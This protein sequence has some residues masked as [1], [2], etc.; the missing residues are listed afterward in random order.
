MKLPAA[1]KHFWRIAL[2][3]VA[4]YGAA[5]AV[6]PSPYHS[7]RTPKMNDIPPKIAALF[8]KTKPVCF[9]RFMIDLP[10]NAKVIWG[11]LMLP[12]ET[13]VY[14]GQGGMIRAAI[15][16]KVDE[17]TCEKH[18]TEPSMLIGTFDSANPDSKIVVGYENT[19][20]DGGAQ[21]FSY[22]RLGK[23][24]FMQ[25]IPSKGLFVTD[26]NDPWGI[27]MDKNAYKPVVE[28]L[29]DIASRFRPRAEDEIPTDPGVCIEGGFL[30]AGLDYRMELVSIGFR[31]PEYPDVS[32]SVRTWSTDDPSEEDTLA[33]ALARGRK[34]AGLMGLGELYAK[35]RTL[36][37]GERVIGPWEGGEALGRKPG[38]DGGPSVHEFLFRSQGVGKDLLRPRVNID[39][40]TG[41]N[42]SEHSDR[43]LKPSLAD[44]EVVA[45]WDKLTSSIRVKPVGEAAPPPK[46]GQPLSGNARQGDGLPPRLATGD[47]CPQAGRWRCVENGEM[48]RFVEGQLMPPASFYTP[49]S[50][51]LNRLRGIEYEYSHD[52]PGH[53][54][55]AVGESP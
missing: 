4:L 22:I 1:K 28:D 7:D 11:P 3:A 52:G 47:K 24:G 21:F 39:L 42:D 38:V 13:K 9:S 34:Q 45:L 51:W 30:S 33:S 32:F 27:R 31:F 37:Q 2:L 43:T 25:S 41:V 17:I 10:V 8:E 18:N 20:N 19:L 23:T 29:R 49:A 5:R 55:W 50:G 14:P 35:I 12:H 54:E 53:W 44:E 16:D 48:R 15:H 46:D 40:Y 36:R 6:Q 26:K